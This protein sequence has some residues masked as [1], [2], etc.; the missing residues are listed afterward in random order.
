M[1]LRNVKNKEEILNGS[2]ILISNPKDYCGNWKSV[3]GNSHAIHVEIG[4]GKGQ[5]IIEMARRNPAINFIGIERYDSVVVRAV[6]KALDLPNLRLIRM[7]ALEIDECFCHEVEKLYLNFSDPWPK[8]RH[9]DRRLT[10]SI[11]LKKYDSIFKGVPLI[12]QKTDNQELFEYSL[13]SLSEYGYT[14][15][16][17]CLD[18]YRLEDLSWNVA[19]EYEERFHKQGLPIYYVVASKDFVP[20]ASKILK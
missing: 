8:K 3:F 4:M 5:F 18:L 6:Q 11:F 20:E 19:T 9:H 10:S 16:S 15:K 14:L 17:V 13:V 12:E 1:R 7:N 2:K